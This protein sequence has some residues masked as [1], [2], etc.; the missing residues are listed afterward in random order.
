MIFTLMAKK[1]KSEKPAYNRIKDVL[2]EKGK[3][4]TW[5]AEQLDK[6]FKTVTRYIHNT[7]QPT[8]ETFFQIAKI[9][10][11]NPKELLNS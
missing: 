7:R 3:T 4:Q 5:L 6:D 1:T 8:F 10:K 2:E 9:L 11:V